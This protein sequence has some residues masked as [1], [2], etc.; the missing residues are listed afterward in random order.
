MLLTY[1]DLLAQSF[2]LFAVFFGAVIT[3]LVAGITFHECS[4]ALVAERLGDR[5]ARGMGRISLNPFRHLDPA[6]TFF[7][8]IAGFGWG[9]PVPVNPFRLRLGPK[10]GRALVAGAGP[11]SN[12]LLALIASI[13]VQLDIVPWRSPFLIP[14]RL[15]GWGL[16]DYIGLYLASV[17][18]FNVILAIFNLLPI[19]PLDGFSVAV[20]LLPD[21]LAQTFARLEAYGPGIL[22]LVLVLPFLTGGSINLL[23]EVISPVINAVTQFLSG[24]GARAF[25]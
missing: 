3:A 15:T 23:A 2:T 11:A 9:K 19:A 24:E 4:H 10:A 21:D 12:L 25:G 1:S 6:G 13:P 17:V 16:E 8:F 5:T 20:G 14:F 22:M 18:I 7:L